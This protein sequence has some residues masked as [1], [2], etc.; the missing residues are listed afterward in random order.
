MYTL[1]YY[2]NTCNNI[3]RYT[4]P[5]RDPFVYPE[6][7]VAIQLIFGYCLSS[8]CIY[9]IVLQITLKEPLLV[10]NDPIMIKYSFVF[11]SSIFFAHLS[12]GFISY[13]TL[14]LA[15]S[16]KILS[17]V[18][19]SLFV[20]EIKYHLFQYFSVFLII[21]AIFGFNYNNNSPRKDSNIGLIMIIVS[22]LCD[23]VSSYFSEKI[24][25]TYKPNSL[26]VMKSCCKWGFLLIL[27]LIGFLN[28]FIR[29]KSVL[30]FID[31]FPD[32]LP[33]ILALL[34]CSG[35]VFVFWGLKTLG[36][37]N[38]VIIT[39]SRKIFTFIISVIIF[40]HSIDSNQWVCVV[41]VIIG[42]T[43]DFTVSYF[44]EGEKKKIYSV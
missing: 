28:V 1:D 6:F 13:P 44:N 25:Y 21:I 17:I 10:I 34:S 27:P 3:F 7:V 14:A 18:I 35:Q 19:G 11:L 42:T 29:E 16:C 37:L 9:Y 31:K 24:K 39:T 23:G 43:L 36:S 26:Y 33:D 4:N 41:F 8:L 30:W 5:N 40:D 12:L 38:L 15:K 22:L 32:V 2:K 20:K